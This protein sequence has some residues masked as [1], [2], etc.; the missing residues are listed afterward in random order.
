MAKATLGEVLSCIHQ[1]WSNHLV[2]TVLDEQRIRIDNCST[3]SRSP[4][5]RSF[6]VNWNM[7]W[8]SN[9]QIFREE[10]IL[11]SDSTIWNWILNDVFQI[12]L[13]FTLEVIY[14]KLSWIDFLLLPTNHGGGRSAFGER[15]PFRVGSMH[16]LRLGNIFA[17]GDRPAKGLESSNLSCNPWENTEWP[18]VDGHNSA[19]I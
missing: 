9:F 12:I 10:S 17:I 8:T 1:T 6:W 11:T 19:I 2:L 4:W 14:P 16:L 3:W 7:W 15:R 18:S 5:R 13:C